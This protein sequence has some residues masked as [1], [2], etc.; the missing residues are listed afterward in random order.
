M[1]ELLN[2]GLTPSII[3]E[4]ESHNAQAARVTAVYRDRYELVCAQGQIFGKLKTGA[5]YG[6]G[7]EAFPTV[8]DFVLVQPQQGGDGQIIRTT[9]RRT[10]FA[11]RDPDPNAHAGEQLIAANF[12]YVFI[13][14]SLNRDFNIGRIQRYLVLA[15]Q[16][17][18]VPVIILSKADLAG[19]FSPQLKAVHAAANAIDA[20]PVSVITGLGLD[21]L[22]DYL[23][24]GKT[25]VFL[26]MSGVGKS[27]LLNALIGRDVMEV[28][29]VR[30][31]DSRGRHTTTHRQL[32]MLP[33]GAAV[34][35]TPGMRS[36]GLFDAQEGLSET[37]ADI[38]ALLGTCKFSDCKHENEP[39]CA[40]RAAIEGGA[41]SPKR[42]L[43]YQKLR[44]EAGYAES[45]AEFMRGKQA[46]NKEI[47]MWSRRRK[48]D[49]GIRR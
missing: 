20:I 35:D 40:V 9:S 7:E 17:G 4:G 3:Q 42:W 5:Y 10:F 2:Y 30:E 18:A 39:G 15:R 43:S 48:K 8:G 12:D 16:S 26:G 46:R 21:R 33:S 24:P 47:A 37:F 38:D 31:D 11:R 13:M 49:G 25:V 19:D 22:R 23:T 29:A 32:F 28:S 45:K 1:T 6:G 41:L 34:I 36:L 27:S 14:S 44:H